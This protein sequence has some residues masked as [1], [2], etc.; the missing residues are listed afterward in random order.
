[1]HAAFTTSMRRKQKSA[2]RENRSGEESAEKKPLSAYNRPSKRQNTSVSAATSNSTSVTAKAKL[3]Q[4]FSS[5]DH[6]D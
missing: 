5:T 2:S 3:T 6:C 1:M 4:E